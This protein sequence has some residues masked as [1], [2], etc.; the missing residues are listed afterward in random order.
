MIR[1]FPRVYSAITLTSGDK[2]V[3]ACPLPAGAKVNNVWFELHVKGGALTP[4]N[5]MVWGLHGYV[6]PVLDPDS[7][8]TPDAMWDA[9][10]PKDKAMSANVLDMDTEAADTDPLISLGDVSIAKIVGMTTAPEMTFSREKML[11]WVN[12]GGFGGYD[13]AVNE[14]FPAELVKGKIA[15]NVRVEVPS[16]Y[17]LGASIVDNAATQVGWPVINADGEWTQLQYMEYTLQQAW[18]SLVGLTE[19]G[20]E[21]P[22]EDAMVLI[23]NYLEVAQEDTAG[24]WQNTPLVIVGRATFDVTLPGTP[25][26]VQLT[27]Q[28]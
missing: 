14:Y 17:L 28:P 25:D 19:A 21:S 11:S 7:G 15:S 22:F 8:I 12:A 13:K 18:M 26:R 20:A 10:I 2:V 1:T 27:A 5:V 9:Q 16:Y 4:N 23:S 24:L 6:L 3:F